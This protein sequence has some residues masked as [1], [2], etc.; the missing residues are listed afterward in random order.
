MSNINIRLNEQDK[1]LFEEFA[2]LNGKNL[3]TFIKDTVKEAIEDQ[4]DYQLAVESHEEYINDNKYSISS[5]E[6]MR[7]YGL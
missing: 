5:E 2:K 1:K 6:L 4:F 3:T 7:K